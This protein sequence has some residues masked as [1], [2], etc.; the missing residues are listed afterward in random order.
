MKTEDH[1]CKVQSEN[2]RQ[3]TPRAIANEQQPFTTT[4]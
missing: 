4:A 1:S 3:K 2:N